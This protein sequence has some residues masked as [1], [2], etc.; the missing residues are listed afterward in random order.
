VYGALVAGAEKGLTADDNVA[1]CGE[2]SLAPHAAGLPGTRDQATTVLGQAIS[3][4]VLIPPTGVQ[5]R[6]VAT[7]ARAV[8]RRGARSPPGR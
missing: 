6:P 8:R 3:F 2:I 1:A 7:P 5:A 4:P